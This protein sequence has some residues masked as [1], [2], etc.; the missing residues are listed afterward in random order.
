MELIEFIFSS[1]W[2]WL[3]VVILVLTVSGCVVELVKALRR[4]RK[5]TATRIG[6]RVIIMVEH[7]TCSYCDH[8]WGR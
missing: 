1:F 7:K 8:Y 5:V 3:G 2:V 4:N 6:E